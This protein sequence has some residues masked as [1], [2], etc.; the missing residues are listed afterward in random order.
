M[1]QNSLVC[2]AIS[3][4]AQRAIRFT[5]QSRRPW[6]IPFSWQTGYG[7]FSVSQ[8]NLPQVA[9]YAEQ[10]EEHHQTRTFQEEYRTLCQRHEIEIDERYVWD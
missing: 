7:V 9:G 8:S 5:S 2:R 6:T 10:Q 3:L 4:P 1:K